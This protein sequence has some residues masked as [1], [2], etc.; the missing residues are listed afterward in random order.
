[1]KPI[2]P[3]ASIFV[4]TLA[5]AGAGS[6]WANGGESLPTAS[7]AQR[8]SV[9][10]IS[11]PQST[12]TDA[13]QIASAPSSA[14]STPQLSQVLHTADAPSG[15]ATVADGRSATVAPIK[16]HDHCDAAAP[17]GADKPECK[18]ILDA[19][20][21]TFTPSVA[22]QPAPVDTRVDSS[23]LVNTIVNGGTGT[24]VSL[25]PPQPQ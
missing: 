23:D 11:R 22:L 13:A 25:P 5:I 14:V 2:A 21:D 12:S 19:K 24:V 1:M 15:P 4:A 18:Q 3:L 17:G 10:Q 20:A 9:G 16:G 7:G 8:A 6:A